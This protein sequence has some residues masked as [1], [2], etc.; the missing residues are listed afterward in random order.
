MTRKKSIHGHVTSKKLGCDHIF[1]WFFVSNRYPLY[2]WAYKVCINAVRLF[3]S[4]WREPKLAKRKTTKLQGRGRP[5]LWSLEVFCALLTRATEWYIVYMFSYRSYTPKWILHNN[6]SLKSLQY[7]KSANFKGVVGHA[8]CIAYIGISIRGIQIYRLCV[9]L[10]RASTLRKK[11]LN[12]KGVVDHAL[13]VWKFF[14]LPVKARVMDQ[15]VI[16]LHLCTSHVP[17]YTINYILTRKTQKTIGRNPISYRSRDQKWY[18]LEGNFGQKDFLIQIVALDGDC[19]IICVQ[20]NAKLHRR[21]IHI[22]HR[23]VPMTR[24]KSIHGHVTS[25]K[26]GCDHIFWWFFVS[27]R[28]PL[29]TW[30]YKVCI[31]AVRLFHSPWREPKLA[32]RKT[33]KLQGRGRPILWSLEVFCAI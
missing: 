3:H 29:Y 8:L 22:P 24:K 18:Q 14:V 16:C 32:K 13:E 20:H 9:I 31:N 5:I 25:K 27:N 10:W 1:W 11:A 33:S 12:F 2:T 30:A 26:L 15:N 19:S 7:R 6:R 17:R 28:Y 4:P 21:L 23:F